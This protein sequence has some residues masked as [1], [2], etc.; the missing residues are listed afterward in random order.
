MQPAA[1]PSGL[2]VITDSQP[3]PAD[4]L[5]DRVA[6]AIAGGAVMVQFRDKQN[7]AAQRERTA[8]ALAEMCRQRGVPLII[9]DDIGLA[10]RVDAA[11]VHLGQGD[12]TPGEAR[13]RLGDQAIIGVSCYNRL[14]RARQAQ[15]AGA[16]YVAFGRF[17]PS[18]TKPDAVQ[19]RTALLTE[20]RRELELPVVAIGGITPENGSTL[21][22]AGAHLLAVV[23]GVFGQTDTRAAARHY[24]NLFETQAVP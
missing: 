6:L 5:V 2:Y 23:H 21:V 15:A 8:V 16:S 1:L 10:A 18:T 11:G 24:A 14:E 3:V 4:R 12:A 22:A 19:A 7:P 13:A 20:A 9:N 17:F